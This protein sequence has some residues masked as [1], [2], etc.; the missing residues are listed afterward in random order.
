MPNWCYNNLE[1]NGDE[2]SIRALRERAV[3]K[4]EK[5]NINIFSFE[6]FVPTPPEKLKD[7]DWYDWR[8]AN[9]GTKWNT[10]EPSF[11]SDE[12]R[13]D[14]LAYNF[15]TAWSPPVE[16][17]EK[18]SG[19]YP[20]LTFKMTFEEGGCEIYG[21]V[22]YE[23]G[24]CTDQKEYTW[25]Q[26]LEQNEDYMAFKEEV[27]EMTSEQAIKALEEHSNDIEHWSPIEKLILSKIEDKD[28]PLLINHDWF[29]CNDE[30]IERMKKPKG[31]I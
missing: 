3:E 17:I 8:C 4:D 15:D 6:K 28:L 7:G 29:D 10:D 23:N 21:E 9:W 16:F 25:E 24:E 14:Y 22:T 1:I 18:L 19:M 31:G 11:G 2:K 30:Y 27:M 20:S 26:W 5:G 12:N 13:Y